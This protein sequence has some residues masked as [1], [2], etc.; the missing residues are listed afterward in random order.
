MRKPLRIITFCMS[1]L[2]AVSIA[3]H[4]LCESDYVTI[5]ELR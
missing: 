2:V 5:A 1:L 3:T 4:A